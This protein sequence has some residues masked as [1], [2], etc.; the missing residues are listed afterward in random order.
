[1]RSSPRK[2]SKFLTSCRHPSWP[3]VK[4][5][6]RWVTD[7]WPRSQLS[8]LTKT[9]LGPHRFC[10]LDT[11]PQVPTPQQ[12]LSLPRPSPP[13]LSLKRTE[14]NHVW[15]KTG[16]VFSC[17]YFATRTNIAIHDVSKAVS[18]KCFPQEWSGRFIKPVF[19]ISPKLRTSQKSSLELGDQQTDLRP[20]G[21]PQGQ[22]DSRQQ[23]FR[24][25]GN[26]HGQRMS[27]GQLGRWAAPPGQACCCA[28]FRS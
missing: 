22:P 9:P 20:L 16:L 13:L 4:S 2:D 7:L 25:D 18:Q 11:T 12:P 5:P 21:R 10:I 3:D 28:C 19:L 1:M 24:G 23:R 26:S 6:R 8:G 14:E 15:S 27:Q 17:L